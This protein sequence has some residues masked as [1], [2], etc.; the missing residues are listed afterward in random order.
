MKNPV[1]DTKNK[2]QGKD[3]YYRGGSWYDYRVEGRVSHRYGYDM[4]FLRNLTIGFRL[5]R[6]VK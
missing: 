2:R 1:K 5:A 4:P 6:T 3:R